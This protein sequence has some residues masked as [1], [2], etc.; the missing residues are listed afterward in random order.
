MGNWYM[1]QEL[2]QISL[3]IMASS[4]GYPLPIPGFSQATCTSHRIRQIRQ[5]QLQLLSSRLMEDGAIACHLVYSA[6]WLQ[7]VSA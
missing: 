4:S 1:P 7:A 2:N 3:H 5:A 6:G